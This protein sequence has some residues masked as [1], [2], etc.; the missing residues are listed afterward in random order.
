MV[1]M[2]NMDILLYSLPN[3]SKQIDI[4]QTDRPG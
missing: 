2:H 1:L 3:N 4:E